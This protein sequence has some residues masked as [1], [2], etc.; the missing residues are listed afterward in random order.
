MADPLAPIDWANPR[1]PRQPYQGTVGQSAGDPYSPLASAMATYGNQLPGGFWQDLSR[2]A[3]P[4]VNQVE[5]AMAGVRGAAGEATGVPAAS[6]AGEAL[7]SGD[8]MQAAGQALQALP[9]RLTQLPGMFLS[10]AAAQ[11]QDPRLKR[12]QDLNTEIT[13]REKR[14]QSY[15]NRQF[16]SKAARADAVK[17]ET[18]GIAAART[19][20]KAL[21]DAMDS[22]RSE[23]EAAERR[24]QSAAEWRQT[25]FARK[26]PGAPETMAGVGAAVGSMIPYARARGAVSGFNARI[27]DIDQRWGEAVARAQNNRLSPQNRTAA[28]NEARELQQ[29]FN[30]VIGQ[31]AHNSRLGAAGIGAA[32]TDL[33][34]VLPT[35]IDYIASRP[36]PEGELSKYTMH[37]ISPANPDLYGRLGLGLLGGGALGEIGNELGSFGAQRPTGHASATA[38]LNKRYTKRSR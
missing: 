12:I 30:T 5:R 16:P 28:A 22:E 20:A 34:L 29:E 25:P 8:Y 9:S 13:T 36:D 7:A 37:A 2:W 1:L 14:L 6:R 27:A 18:D 3:A 23:A 11:P 10:E 35:G 21:Q 15:G 26:Y 4:G 32:G 31:G 38:T 17:A 24:R 33:G 19:G